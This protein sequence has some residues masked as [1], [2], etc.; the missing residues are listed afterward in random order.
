VVLGDGRLSLEREPPRHYDVLGIDAFSGDS[1]PM[2]LVT[3]E[4]MAIYLKHL[5]PD[6]VIVFQATNRFVDLLPVVKR[7]AV[8]F[9]LAA[10]NVS[11]EPDGWDGAEYWYSST[12]Q[13]IV[14]RNRA[15]LAWPRIA[16]VADEIPDRPELPTF[17]DAHHNLLR[18]LK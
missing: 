16:E 7:L 10:L 11:D 3:R 12:D 14:T 9:G 8:E 6:G 17:T 1:I 2:H 5:N 13:I 15:L 18:I 4:A